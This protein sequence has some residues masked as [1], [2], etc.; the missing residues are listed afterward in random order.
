MSM[1]ALEKEQANAPFS[2]PMRRRGQM[3]V[4]FT[5]GSRSGRTMFGHVYKIGERFTDIQLTDGAI[6]GGVAHI[7]DPK[8]K[9]NQFVRDKGAWDH[10]EQEIF[11]RRER[12]SVLRRLRAIE[13]AVLSSQMA[14]REMLIDRC[15]ELG[16]TGYSTMKNGDI[17]EVIAKKYEELGID[18]NAIL[19]ENALLADEDENASDEKL[20]QL[21]NEPDEP[22]Q[23]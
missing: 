2:P 10:T 17:R 22:C 11:V 9:H 3:V 16:L 8:V 20:N 14:T 19:T 6:I 15:K 18:V 13:N 4:Y 23:T 7:D 5:T 21:T 12:N 1:T